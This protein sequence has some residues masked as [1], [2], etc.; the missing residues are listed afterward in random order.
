MSIT[1]FD[2]RAIA[3]LLET[4]KNHLV[5]W[6]VS[7]AIGS[8]IYIEMGRHWSYRLK[9]GDKISVGSTSLSLEADDWTIWHGSQRV[10]DA[11][12]VSEDDIG[13][14]SALFSG[15]KLASLKFSRQYRKCHIA[16]SNEL[17]ITLPAGAD[18]DDLCV[19]HL[20]DGTIIGCN[21]TSGFQSD[22]SKSEE[23]AA[24][25]ALETTL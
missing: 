10:A 5:C 13:R 25:Y 3:A 2:N 9:S 20:P 24:A 6:T 12:S 21:A 11:A 15:Q 17:Q 8:L 1:T 14:I 22:G 4:F 7:R 16:F 23:K 18:D 19:L